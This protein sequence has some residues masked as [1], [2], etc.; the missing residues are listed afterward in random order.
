MKEL[1]RWGFCQ[2]E[3]VLS[4]FFFFL[5]ENCQ[6]PW[7]PVWVLYPWYC[8][9]YVHTA[10][11]QA[12]AYCRGD[13]ECL[14]RCGPLGAAQG[15][16]WHMGPEQVKTMTVKNGL[17]MPGVALLRALAIKHGSQ[18]L[19]GSSPSSGW[20]GWSLLPG[21][22]RSYPSWGNLVPRQPLTFEKLSRAVLVNLPNI[23]TLEYSSSCCGD[24]LLFTIYTFITISK[25]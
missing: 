6:K 15:V 10:P 11:K 4:V 18:D 16:G 7:F 25:L 13:R 2:H 23:T 19:L 22:S 3:H 1:G 17:G 5:G 8:H 12:W 14:P 9:E 21:M 20:P 24:S